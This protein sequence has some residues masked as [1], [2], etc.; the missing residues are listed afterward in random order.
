MRSETPDLPKRKLDTLLIQPSHLVDE[1]RCCPDINSNK[2]TK[3]YQHTGEVVG[4]GGEMMGWSR[5]GLM[6][7]GG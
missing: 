6:N 2:Q 5:D 1:L 3:S 4:G 7:W